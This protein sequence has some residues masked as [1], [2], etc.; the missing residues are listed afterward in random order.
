MANYYFLA[1][2]LPPLYLDK[3][4]ELSF[5]ELKERLVLNLNRRDYEKTVVLRRFIDLTNIRSLLLEE[6]I[7]PRGNLD[8]KALDEALLIR[9]ILPSYVFDFLDRYENVS[10]Q[11]KHFSGLLSL[12]FLEEIPHQKGFLR[13]YLSFEHEWRLVATALRA[14]Q[15][16]KDL[17]RELQFED[18]GDP[19]VAQILAQKDAAHYEPPFEYLDLK[20]KLSS[21]GTDPWLQYRVFAEY[22][23]VKIEEMIDHPLF[24]IEW[25]LAYMAQLLIVEHANELDALKGRMILDT[26]KAG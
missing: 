23:F 9:N 11:V 4:P 8:E 20:E 3:K 18:F 13:K 7:D 5:A 10:D 6:P 21:C 16:G 14:K 12:F 15:Y 24:S 22:R 26:F 1:A 25:I 17:I 2:S 19:L